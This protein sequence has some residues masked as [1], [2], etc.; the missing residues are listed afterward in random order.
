LGQVKRVLGLVVQDR[1]QGFDGEP[2]T[3]MIQ[4]M[5]LPLLLGILISSL[6][7]TAAQSDDAAPKAAR[8]IHLGWRAPDAELFTLAVTVKESVPGSFFMVCGWN[9]GYFGLQELH[10]GRKVIIFSVWDPTTGDD[11]GSV[12]LEERVECLYQ[13]PAMRIR[14]FGGEGTG[15]QCMGEFPWKT[16]ETIR[17]LVRGQ[18]QGDRTAYSGYVYESNAERWRHLVT[19][20]TRTGG[21][22]LRGLYSFLEDF[23]RDGA[24]A[25][26]SRKAQFSHGWVRTTGG[27]WISLVRAQF[28]ASNSDQ[29][30]RDSIDAGLIQ[31]QFFLQTGGTTRQTQA[32]GSLLE[33]SPLPMALP[34]FKAFQTHPE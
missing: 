32:L 33:I 29:E 10:D 21:Q 9:T 18:P 28:T 1:T 15:G 23:R 22:P 14:R 11:P 7:F 2:I 31:D 30:A 24:S 25:Q 13:D 8:S 20:R 34:S 5:H 6:V 12:P 19:F 4:P 16:D 3:A 27:D 17:F 26:Q